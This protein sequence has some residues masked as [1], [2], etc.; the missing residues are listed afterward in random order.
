MTKKEKHVV[1][2]ALCISRVL[3][4][5]GDY[6]LSGNQ[7]T[8]PLVENNTNHETINENV[9]PIDQNRLNQNLKSD[10]QHI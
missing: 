7:S 1:Y 5:F 9:K 4:L 8:D 2:L 6:F 3:F 10:L